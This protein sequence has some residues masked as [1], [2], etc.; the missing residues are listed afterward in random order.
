MEIDSS[1]RILELPQLKYYPN[2]IKVTNSEQCIILRAEKKE[3]QKQLIQN[4]SDCLLEH[5]DQSP[6]SVKNNRSVSIAGGKRDYIVSD[7]IYTEWQG[8]SCAYAIRVSDAYNSFT[9][10]I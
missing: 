5:Q 6:D 10:V 7:V 9:K 1:F 8:K 4:L 3:A 2:C